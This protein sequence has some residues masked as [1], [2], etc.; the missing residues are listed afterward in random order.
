MKIF[1]VYDLGF[2][3]FLFALLRQD[4]L[5]G[6][7]FEGFWGGLN[8][9]FSMEFVGCNLSRTKWGFSWIVFRETYPWV[10]QMWS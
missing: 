10:G 2:K 9:N 5:F 3:S 7:I 1:Y 6:T 4:L 8:G